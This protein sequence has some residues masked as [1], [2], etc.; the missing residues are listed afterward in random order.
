MPYAVIT[1]A[2]QGIGK[3]IT[4]RFLAEGFSVGI[5]AR[6]EADLA[7]LQ[8]EWEGKYPEAKV[9]CLKA[10]FT[11]KEEVVSFGETVLN[12]FGQIDVLVNNAGIYMPGTL[13]DEAE[14]HLETLMAVNLFSAY[15]LT[16]K[17]LPV[18]KEMKSGHIFNMCSVAS[19]KAYPG[20]G[21][22]SITKY[23]LMG[24]S[25]NLRYELMGDDIRV[26]AICP[27]A[28]DSRS[29]AGSDL[30]KERIMEATDV[31]N[32]VWAAYTLSKQADVETI[33]MRPIKG[34]L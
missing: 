6:S 9:L 8:R 33:V 14:G 28:T 1:G 26:T 18:M 34:D 23:A 22:Y 32:M 10:D 4:E 29:W 30:P 21:A 31:A 2:T 27:G 19:L 24:F 13:A 3:A 17:L 15:H 25:D 16:R 5:C 12:E 11:S 7:A 20:G